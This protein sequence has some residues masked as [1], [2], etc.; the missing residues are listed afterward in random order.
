MAL[1]MYSGSLDNIR[2][3][4]GKPL[5]PNFVARKTSTVLSAIPHAEN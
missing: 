1:S 2:V 5:T 3:P 4:S